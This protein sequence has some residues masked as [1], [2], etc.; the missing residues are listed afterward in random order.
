M[1]AA[2]CLL[3]KITAR[4]RRTVHLWGSTIERREGHLFSRQTPPPN[5]E[6]GRQL[7]VVRKSG[8]VLIG[9][10]FLQGPW[11]KGGVSISH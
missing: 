9:G 10:S 1:L 6:S 5:S 4:E 8:A 2:L 3:R 11:N 7:T